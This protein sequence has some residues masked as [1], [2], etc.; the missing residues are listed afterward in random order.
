MG[1]FRQCVISDSGD[2][3]FDR[4]PALGCNADDDGDV[5]VVVAIAIGALCVVVGCSAAAAAAA[6]AAIYRFQTRLRH[7][8]SYF[9]PLLA[10]CFELI[11]RDRSPKSAALALR[12]PPS[13]SLCSSTRSRMICACLSC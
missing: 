6:G 9:T 1:F 5:V 10:R 2:I 4:V 7:T 11:H 13:G 8:L 3:D 12:P